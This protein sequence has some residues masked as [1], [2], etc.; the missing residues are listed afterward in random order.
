MI[1][2][3]RPF[4]GK[5]FTI[6]LLENGII[7]WKEGKGFEKTITDFRDIIR[8][9]EGTEN[10]IKNPLGKFKTSKEKKEFIETQQKILNILNKSL[11]ALL[12]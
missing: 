6:S 8:L 11:N 12:K 1:K 4:K 7:I 10:L 3:I 9:K 5:Q 2:K